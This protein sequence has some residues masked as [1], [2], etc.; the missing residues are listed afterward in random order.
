MQRIP[1]YSV[2]AVSEITATI[3]LKNFRQNFKKCHIVF[4]RYAK[5]TQEQRACLR[6]ISYKLYTSL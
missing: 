3:L 6:P 1:L 5:S 4:C 2:Q